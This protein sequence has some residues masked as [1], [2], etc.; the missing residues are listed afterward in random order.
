MAHYVV[1]YNPLSANLKGEEKS[2][3]KMLSIKGDTYSMFDIRRVSNYEKFFSLMNDED[4]L[5]ICGGDGTLNRF[6]N[7]TDGL[8]LPKNIFYYPA[9]T[10]N[11]FANDISDPDNKGFYEISQYLK[12]LPFVIVNGQKHRFL[13]GI[14]YGIDGYCCERADEIK[15]KSTKEVNYTKIALG[16][17]F[18]YFKPRNAKITVDGKTKSYKKV[19]LAPC[20]NGRYYGGGMMPTPNQDRLNADNSLSVLVYH[21]SGKL[22]TAMQF[23]SIFSGSHTKYKKNCEILSGHNFHIEFDKPCAL[24]IDG[25]TVLNVSSYDAYSYK[26]A[27][28]EATL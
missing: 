5:L 23:P 15:T 7:D 10:G 25:E 27:L 2:K 14:G 20:M 24:Q 16:G 11:D 9:G 26:Y 19:W 21:G 13:N 3:S 1:L 22:L 17:L 4:N 18:F 28:S 8:S 12:N 6:I